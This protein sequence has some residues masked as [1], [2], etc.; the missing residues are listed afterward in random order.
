VLIGSPSRIMRSRLES[1]WAC[2]NGRSIWQSPPGRRR[3]QASACGTIAVLRSPQAR[4]HR[5][6]AHAAS[7]ATPSTNKKIPHDSGRR[8]TAGY[9]AR[10][11]DGAFSRERKDG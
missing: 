10:A 1:A 5:S 6:Y 11:C 7:A 9:A 3:R 8:R 2:A 4:H